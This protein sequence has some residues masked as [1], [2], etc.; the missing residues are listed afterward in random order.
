MVDNE[1]DQGWF[2]RL[3]NTFHKVPCMRTSL[4]YGVGGG[5]GTGL[6]YF[7]YSSRVKRASDLGVLSFCVITFGT[8]GV[9]RYSRAKKK[10]ASQRLQRVHGVEPLDEI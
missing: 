9:C 10:L 2:S 1:N 8:F 6:A 4:L 7:L 5:V 3:S